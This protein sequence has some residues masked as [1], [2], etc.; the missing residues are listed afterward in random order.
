MQTKY[1]TDWKAKVAMNLQMD[2]IRQTYYFTTVST[3]TH[4]QFH[5]EVVSIIDNGHLPNSNNSYP[6]NKNCN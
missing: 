3:Q 2:A 1:G 5:N 4:D 6:A